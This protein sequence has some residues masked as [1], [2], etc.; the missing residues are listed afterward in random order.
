MIGAAE[1]KTAP[2]PFEM[3]GITEQQSESEPAACQPSFPWQQACSPAGAGAKQPPRYTATKENA[4]AKI[5]TAAVRR[6][7]N[8]PWKHDRSNPSTPGRAGRGSV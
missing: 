8:D 7:I 2:P 4:Q 1:A 3:A 6:R 5:A